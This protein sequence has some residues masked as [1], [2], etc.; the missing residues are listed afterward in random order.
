MTLIFQVG[1]QGGQEGGGCYF[2]HPESGGWFQDGELESRLNAGQSFDMSV[3][4]IT[5][6]TPYDT[7]SK[8]VPGAVFV[9]IMRKPLERFISLFNFR[10]DLKRHYKVRASF[11]MRYFPSRL[12]VKLLAVFEHL[13]M[14]HKFREAI[15]SWQ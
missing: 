9:T 12:N 6:H 3:R 8:L 7:L 5:P 14:C 11:P 1:S 2:L 15:R 13:E 10:H 4:H